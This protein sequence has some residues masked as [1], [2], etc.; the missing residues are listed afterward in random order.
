[1]SSELKVLKEEK[2][3]RKRIE[4]EREIIAGIGRNTV[5]FRSPNLA[6]GSPTDLEARLPFCSATS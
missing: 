2:K 6:R 4:K 3:K 5:P 1:V